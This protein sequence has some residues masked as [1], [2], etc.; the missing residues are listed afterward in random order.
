[1]WFDS[2]NSVKD[3]TGEDHEAA[4]VPPQARAVLTDFDKRPVH[5]EV[6]D[7]REQPR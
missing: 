2:L 7:R 5:Y 4:H 1:M 6:L 3:F